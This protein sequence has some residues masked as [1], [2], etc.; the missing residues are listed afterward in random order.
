MDNLQSPAAVLRK[1]A[2]LALI[3][4]GAI[5][6]SG[7]L[8]A[9]LSI[10]LSFGVVLAGFALVGFLIWL[11][12]RLLVAGQRVALDNARDL[13]HGMAQVGARAGS[14]AWHVVSFPPRLAL[15]TL[16]GLYRLTRSTMRLGLEL[17]L[18]AVAGV[19]VGLLAGWL[20]SAPGHD[21]EVAIATNAVAGGALGLLTGV[22][23][24]VR[25]RRAPAVQPQQ[26]IG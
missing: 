19:L 17:G 25:D 16:G 5:T 3:G 23:L 14:I 24:A 12:F 11:P 13:A 22:V 10:L 7:P 6:L 2:L 26:V 20:G 4:F 15:A 9:L 1:V 8:L 18:P 21:M